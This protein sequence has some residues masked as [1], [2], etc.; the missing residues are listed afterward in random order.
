MGT[1]FFGE[2]NIG[3]DPTLK[4]FPGNGNQA[5]RGVLRLNVRF[6]NLVPGDDGMVDRGGFWANVE[7]WGRYV[8]QWANLYQRGQRVLV[9]GRMV[10]DTWEKDG[11]QQTAFK[12]QADRVGILPFRISQ[13]V[14]EASAGQWQNSGQPPSSASSSQT[15]P[16]VG[17]QAQHHY[18]E[19]TTGQSAHYPTQPMGMERGQ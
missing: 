14:M 5:P 2:G 8:E 12:V 17:N 4:M 7:L 15:P 19:Q 13:V 18:Q 9:A 1:R 6:D 3:S 10:Q 16:E 11:E